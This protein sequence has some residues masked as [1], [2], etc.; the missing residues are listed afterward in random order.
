MCYDMGLA[1]FHLARSVLERK[2]QNNRNLPHY[3][4]GEEWK[5]QH[6]DADWVLIEDAPRTQVHGTSCETISHLLKEG[7]LSC[8]L[9]FLRAFFQ[10]HR[11]LR[12]F[13]LPGC[14]SDLVTRQPRYPNSNIIVPPHFRT[15]VLTFLADARNNQAHS[16]PPHPIHT[17][18]SSL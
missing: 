8:G 18:W 2:E 6:W 5:S 7:L 10:T 17:L 16:T 14:C 1:H 9:L 12:G 13:T 3:H 15:D 11:W 4:L